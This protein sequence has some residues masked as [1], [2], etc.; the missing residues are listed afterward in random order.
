MR[1]FLHHHSNPP[2][3]FII[4]DYVTH[5]SSRETANLTLQGPGGGGNRHS[6]LFIL[7]LGQCFLLLGPWHVRPRLYRQACELQC[8]MGQMQALTASVS[9]LD[10]CTY[11]YPGLPTVQSP[12]R[13]PLAGPG[14]SLQCMTQ[15]LPEGGA[16]AEVCQDQLRVTEYLPTTIT[17][18]PGLASSLT[19]SLPTGRSLVPTFR[20]QPL[21][22]SRA[23]P[24]GTREWRGG[25]A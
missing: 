25:G 19:S 23:G 17:P 18:R 20:S 3:T 12:E 7:S 11:F 21:G 24:K 10:T 4:L 13:L 5:L 8:Y 22:K 2:H 9:P 15:A 1:T 16:G 6:R 14:H